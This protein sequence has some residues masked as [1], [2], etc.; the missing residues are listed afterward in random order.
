MDKRVFISYAKPDEPFAS[1]IAHGLE[2]MGIKT[3]IA[4]DQIQ[5]GTLW[6]MDISE[7][8]GSSSHTLVVLSPDSVA[9]HW[10]KFEVS[11][12]VDLFTQGKMKIIPVLWA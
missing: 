3:W 2:D 9:S 7:A 6:P 1:R 8:L 10:V 5:A 4:C 12:A 11:M